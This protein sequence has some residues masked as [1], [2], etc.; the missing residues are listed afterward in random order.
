MKTRYN[1]LEIGC[2]TGIKL[3]KLARKGDAI[4]IDL[5]QIAI[6]EIHRSRPDLQAFCMRCEKMSF[7]DNRFDMVYCYDVLEHVEDL[8]ESLR[9]ISRVLK[10]GG[11]LIVEVPFW[12]SE[13]IL[14]R[15]RP[16]YWSEI[17]HRRAFT[18]D[19]QQQ[20][21]TRHHFRL[22]CVRKKNFI[23]HLELMAQFKRGS[24]IKNQRGAYTKDIPLIIKVGLML[25]NE[26][27]FLTPVKYLA[28]IWLITLPIGKLCS[29][30]FPKTLHFEYIKT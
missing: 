17:G 8:D 12:K 19:L 28:P 23:V 4:G 11:K 14:R 16:S 20:I 30:F 21:V 9:E 2:G 3:Q 13:E 5:S 29:Q 27:L 15:I 26:D 18:P 10:H 22:N 24:G 25:F 1:I 6:D 7:P